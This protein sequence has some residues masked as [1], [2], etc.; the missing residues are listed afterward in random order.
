MN[1]SSGLQI[2]RRSA[3]NQQRSRNMAFPFQKKQKHRKLGDKAKEYFYL[4]LYSMLEAGMDLKKALDVFINQQKKEVDKNLFQQISDHLING[5][6][7]SECMQLS[8][9]FT[10]YEY[11]CVQIGEESGQQ[12]KV[13][14]ELALFFSNKVKVRKQLLKSLSYPIVILISSVGAVSFMMAFI[15]P[16][17]TDIFKRF[18]GELPGLTRFF[19]ALSG[20]L[21]KNSLLILIVLVAG[22]L[23]LG[24]LFQNKEFKKRVQQFY[25]RIPYVGG[26]VSGVYNARFCSSMSLLI[27][28]K[29]PLINAIQLVKKMVDFYPIQTALIRVEEEIMKGHSFHSSL[30][31]EN[32]FDEKTISMIRIG[33]EV[34]RLDVFFEKLHQRF[35][36]EVDMKSN[37]LNTFLEPLI[38]MLLGLVI[39]LILVAMYLPMFKLSTSMGM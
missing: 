23:G 25:I 2:T 3:G 21:S 5:K 14:N 15:V 34:N 36:D 4:E 8:Q 16:M 29:V 17:F 19:I 22:G 32:L 35:M 33:E 20:V 13:L 39:G 7:L 18:N 38:I 9:V 31:K 28:A 27:G 1:N 11:Y 37:A 12:L 26:L 10:P 6:T 24:Y 30:S